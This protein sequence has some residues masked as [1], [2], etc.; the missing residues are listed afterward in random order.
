MEEWG[1]K[2][3]DTDRPVK[4]GDVIILPVNNSYSLELPKEVTRPLFTMQFPVCPWI[5]TMH[6][7]SGAGFYADMWG[8][9]PFA[10]G[11]APQEVYHA[12]LV[13]FS[14]MGGS[15]GAF[16]QAKQVSPN[17]GMAK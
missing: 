14:P 16:G 3:L 2:P 13:D 8:P 12:F 15:Y 1:A 11:P 7:Q 5:S 9:L 10:F 6:L 4:N 17:P